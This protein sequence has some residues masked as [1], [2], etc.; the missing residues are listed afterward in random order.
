MPVDRYVCLS[1][2]PCANSRLGP[3]SSAG[4]PHR[5]RLPFHACTHAS[6]Q[7]HTRT[8]ASASAFALTPSLT[9]ARLAHTYTVNQHIRHRCSCTCLYRHLFEYVDTESCKRAMLAIVEFLSRSIIQSLYFSELW[10][11]IIILAIVSGIHS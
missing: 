3:R 5:N 9:S 11:P 7:V 2:C 4:C 10:V 6:P 1:V 8:P